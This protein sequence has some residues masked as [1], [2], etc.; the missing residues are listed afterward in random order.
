MNR[1]RLL[2]MLGFAPAAAAVLPTTSLAVPMPPVEPL[3]AWTKVR[4]PKAAWHFAERPL[5]VDVT[6]RVAFADGSV[7]HLG[8]DDRVLTTLGYVNP[9]TVPDA[10][11]RKAPQVTRERQY[12]PV[13][14]YLIDGDGI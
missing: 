14:A 1:R 10:K 6:Q 9:D 13:H 2:T 12:T 11:P 8:E 7:L 5:L 4:I 3:A